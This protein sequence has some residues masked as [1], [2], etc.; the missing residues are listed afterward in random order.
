[1][2][3]EAGFAEVGGARLY[4]EVAGSGDPIVLIH[5]NAGDRRHWDAQFEVLAT[6]HRAIRYDVRGFGKSSTPEV[7]EP[8]G[9]HD[10]LAGLLATLGAPRAHIVGLSMGSAIAADFVLAYPEMS[11][12]LVA[13]GPWVSGYN[14]AAAEGID[15][16]LRALPAIVEE[17][18]VRAAADYWLASP[19]FKA[20]IPDPVVADR[21]REIAY[22]YSFWHFS[23]KD[24][25]RYLDPPAIQRMASIAVPTLIITAD[26]DLE[27]CREV[28][29][30]LERAVAGA[31]KI[32]IPDAGHVMHM[33]RPAEFNRILLEFLDGSLEADEG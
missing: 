8:Y 17:A 24:P 20:S 32:V 19:A 9:H 15:R 18:G 12:S 28:A 26:H 13:V 4:Y 25:V 2:R 30:L 22:D 16:M 1:M 10:D 7:G 11:G 29:D 6:G 31:E 27:A 21:L 3:I 33:D 5:G 23:H 14:G